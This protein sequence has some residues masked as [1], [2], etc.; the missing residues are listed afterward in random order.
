MS[1]SDQKIAIV[2]GANSGL[3]LETALEL[4]GDSYKVVLACRSEANAKAAIAQINKAVTDPDVDF[5][6]LNLIDRES[7]RQFAATFKERYG[8]LNLLINNAGVM[9]PPYT[10]TA[11]DLELQF[12]ANHMGHFY[13]TSLLIERLDQDYETR[14]I[15]VSSLAA[16]RPYADIY[17]D[18]LNFIGNYDDG[19]KLYGMSGMVAYSQS[20]MANILFTMELKDR[21]AA[22]GKKIKAIV[23]HPGASNTQLS[24]NMPLYLRLMAPVLTRFMNIST[25]QQGAESLMYAAFRNDVEAGDFIGPTGQDERTGQ[26]GRVPLP[27]KAS[28]KA[29]CEKLWALSEEKLGITFTIEQNK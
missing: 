16:R 25:Q 4:A 20:K 24:R 13:L 23:V 11:N 2:T 3:G 22:A 27:E 28:D 5:I 14:I 15:N 10:I 19:P 21:L 17:F 29:L 9:G 6:P 1:D 8:Y 12:D 7:I 26:P 18:N